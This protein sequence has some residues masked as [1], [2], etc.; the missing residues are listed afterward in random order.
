MKYIV[1][2]NRDAKRILELCE[3]ALPLDEEE[4]EVF[5]NTECAA[6]PAVRS[7]VCRLLQAVEDSGSFM[8]LEETD[9]GST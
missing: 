1:S 7:Q 3:K 5:L 8:Q 6:E 9:K 2:E 4:R